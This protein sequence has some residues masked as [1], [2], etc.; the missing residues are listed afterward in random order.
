MDAEVGKYESKQSRKERPGSGRT[1]MV[2][3]FLKDNPSDANSKARRGPYFQWLTLAGTSGNPNQHPHQRRQQWDRMSTREKLVDISRRLLVP[4][5][6]CAIMMIIILI[7]V[8]LNYGMEETA[9]AEPTT[10]P[11][12]VPDGTPAEDQAQAM[13]IYLTQRG[14]ISSADL[15]DP[16]SA[17]SKALDWIQQ[18]TIAVAGLPLDDTGRRQLS[19]TAQ[20][21]LVQRY[22]LAVLYY[23]WMPASSSTSLASAAEAALESMNLMPGSGNANSAAAS[24]THEWLTATG[25]CHWIGI[26]CK[27]AVKT[28]QMGVQTTVD[29]HDEALMANEGFVSKLNLTRHELTGTLPTILSAM[30]HLIEVDLSHNQLEGDLGSAIDWT[31][32]SQLEYL[33]L[34]NNQFTGSVPQQ[35]E[36]LER[37]ME[38]DVS[39]NQLAGPLPTFVDE[40]LKLEDLEYLYLN[41]NALTGT[42]PESFLLDMPHLENIDLSD[43]KFTG[44]LPLDVI[45][46][47]KKLRHF[48]AR[49]NQL[50][51]VL[52]S[53]VSDLMGE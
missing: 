21:Q 43:N 10:L 24:N 36:H 15:K 41:G 40:Q 39:N 42:I 52:P 45:A 13:T 3:V 4:L 35:W 49:N 46:E 32:W 9:S 8:V 28:S 7:T 44:S 2:E 23:T 29:A 16:Q 51:G 31:K 47:L 38:I 53:T 22:V 6:L 11:P 33:L 34:S 17:P 12:A 19:S 18:D 20:D 14:L 30:V 1:S 26:T 25:E 37:V 5:M 48:V 50:T 27:D